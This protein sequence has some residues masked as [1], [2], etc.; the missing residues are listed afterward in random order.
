MNKMNYQKELEKLL[1]KLE[2]G[3]GVGKEA[4]ALFLHSCCAPC[5]SY[6]LEYLCG[7]FRITVFYYN[8]NISES[9]EYVRRVA[10]QK[11]LIEA[12]NREGRG[13]PISVIEG[14]YDPQLFFQT[15]Q[16][17]EDCPEGGERC[18][19]CFDLRLRETAHRAR[20][21]GYDYFGTTLTISP[22]KNAE[23]LNQIGTALSEE[24][25]ISWLPSD[26]KKR[27]GYK[28]S[29]ELSEEY[30]LYRQDYCGCAF[31]KAER[32]R[33]KREDDYLE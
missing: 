2:Q 5:S 17:L 1:Q 14:D 8:P 9:A 3:Q 30:G 25:G 13:Y 21:G 33:N 7:R 26:F 11:R 24:Y 29:V 6:V 27:N 22:L 23:K 4:P 28:R 12:Y 10:E 20:E 18:F 15:A 32:E 16:G 31:S 19:R